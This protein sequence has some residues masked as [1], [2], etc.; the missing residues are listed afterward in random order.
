MRKCHIEVTSVGLTH[1][2]PIIVWTCTII[3]WPLHVMH[4]PYVYVGLLVCNVPLTLLLL[5]VHVYA[6]VYTMY[7]VI[8]YI[9]VYVGVCTIMHACI[10]MYVCI[11]IV[12]GPEFTVIP[13]LY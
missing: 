9:L 13:S 7:V 5:V 2:R 3:Q 1:A 10:Y 6:T 12:V 4:E 11:I 8:M